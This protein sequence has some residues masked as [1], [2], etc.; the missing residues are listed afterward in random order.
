MLYRPN[1]TDPLVAEDYVY[2][3]LQTEVN[4]TRDPVNIV[5]NNRS[6]ITHSDTFVWVYLIQMALKMAQ[7][8]LEDVSNIDIK[9]DLQKEEENFSDGVVTSYGDY[10]QL[11]VSHFE[12]ILKGSQPSLLH[13]LNLFGITVIGSASDETY[14]RQLYFDAP[15]N[16]VK[17]ITD[18][19]EILPK[20]QGLKG[21]LYLYLPK[22]SITN[23]DVFHL[24]QQLADRNVVVVNA[25]TSSV[26]I[27][28]EMPDEM[29][30]DIYRFASEDV[31]ELFK[32]L[33]QSADDEPFTDL[34]KL[35][36]LLDSCDAKDIELDY[37]DFLYETS[38]NSMK[39]LSDTYLRVLAL[40]HLQN[41]KKVLNLVHAAVGHE[42]TY[43]NYLA[44]LSDRREG[45]LSDR[46]DAFLYKVQN[47]VGKLVV[48]DFGA[49]G[50]MFSRLN[51]CKLSDTE[52]NVLPCLAVPLDKLQ[53]AI[54]YMENR[55]SVTPKNI[56]GK[57]NS[58]S[59]VLNP[60]NYGENPFDYRP[61][62]ICDPLG[63][64]PT[65]CNLYL[66][67]A[68]LSMGISVDDAKSVEILP[69]VNTLLES[70]FLN[71]F[72]KADILEYAD[73]SC[74]IDLDIDGDKADLSSLYQNTYNGKL[75]YGVKVDVNERTIARNLHEKAFI[76][77]SFI[78]R[79]L[80][81]FEYNLNSS[82]TISPR[83]LNVTD[84]ICFKCGD[85]IYIGIADNFK[86]VYK[87]TPFASLVAPSQ[88]RLSS[89]KASTDLV[90]ELP[91]QK[92]DKIIPTS[93]FNM[94]DQVPITLES[95]FLKFKPEKPIDE[96]E[97]YITYGQKF[98]DWTEFFVLHSCG[99]AGKNAENMEQFSKLSQKDVPT[100]G[101]G[102]SS[103][104]YAAF[105]RFKLGL[106]SEQEYKSVVA[107]YSALFVKGMLLVPMYSVDI[108]NE[109]IS[110][111][112]SKEL[113][114]FIDFNYFKDVRLQYSPISVFG[115]FNRKGKNVTWHTTLLKESL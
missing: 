70:N 82:T 3:E 31:K 67:D 19:E 36:S 26:S 54:R 30:S 73:Y 66:T 88:E 47:D 76:V 93:T 35:Y 105:T 92:V 16:E 39:G 55:I 48:T 20:Y 62:F 110:I 10:R 81:Y 64:T 113:W 52:N 27:P 101:V 112:N 86:P 87:V 109:R 98:D 24:N 38:F 71:D 68:G 42:V 40:F 61:D 77:K 75:I 22:L 89:V 53:A 63:A 32:S 102:C 21:T 69:V 91:E 78:H 7:P 104:I 11:S 45:T 57:A 115:T 56:P 97:N 58:T 114:D 111:C 9:I 43:L 14:S 65:S 80:R 4:I 29:P 23:I 28:D 74:P 83:I 46:L 96:Y 44:D 90:Y 5:V 15:S 17:A 85:E 108:A 79:V 33:S 25:Y 12:N 51:D 1:K 18:I 41:P 34:I 103:A 84:L 50:F 59:Y 94:P 107:E 49:S 60:L 95:I 100:F 106:L 2:A 99:R 72:I 13:S 6:I 8:G 37:N